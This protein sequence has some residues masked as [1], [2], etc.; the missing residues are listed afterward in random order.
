MAVRPPPAVCDVLDRL[1]R[2]GDSA[3][4]FTPREQWHV[5]LRFI[6][7]C[8]P[9]RV[10][11]ALAGERFRGGDAV[12]GPRVETLGRRVV[13]VP[14]SGLEELAAQVRRA[15]AQL[16]Q[17]P[18]QSFRGHLTLARSKGKPTGPPIGNRVSGGFTASEME[19]VASVTG[20]AGAVHR[21]LA[22]YP[23]V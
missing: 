22:R 2:P 18:E 4:R 7:D 16:G 23:L 21:V 11:D 6:G 12:L 13:V 14:V 8:D 10:L 15:T 20:Q 17:P 9:A 5:T 3:L 1:D 19:L